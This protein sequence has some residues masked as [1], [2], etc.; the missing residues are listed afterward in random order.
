MKYLAVDPGQ[1]TGLALYSMS[2][3]TP[4][5]AE[6]MQEDWAMT[7]ADVTRQLYG[8]DALIVEEFTIVGARGHEANDAIEIIGACRWLARQAQVPL[9]RQKP[10][11][12]KE[13]S[14]DEKLKALGWYTP[15]PA[16]HGRDASR[17]LLLYMARAR[18][19]DPALFV[20]V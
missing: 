12:A 1:T 2:G 8:L 7:L 15:A 3:G 5:F 19:I 17:H 6:W 9:I 11:D 18:K 4:Q 10:V 14:T 16:D 20:A 13:F